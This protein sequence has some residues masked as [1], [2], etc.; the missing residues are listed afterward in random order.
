M[1]DP[2]IS[3]PPN[4]DLDNIT[5]NEDEREELLKQKLLRMENEMNMLRKSLNDSKEQKSQRELTSSNPTTT[6]Y[7]VNNLERSAQQAK[8]EL[9]HKQ[10]L[11]KRRV[12]TFR[13]LNNEYAPQIVDLKE[14][15][16]QKWINKLYLPETVLDELLQGKKILRLPKL[17][18]KVRPPKFKEPDYS[19]WV[20][21]G[22]V[23]SKS[24][25]KITNTVN[26][27][28]KYIIF[29]L[30]DFTFDIKL[31]IFGNNN[32]SKYFNLEIGGLIA[33]L[34]PKILPWRTE[35]TNNNSASDVYK[36]FNLSIRHDCNNILEIGKSRDFG[37][38]PIRNNNQS[39]NSPINKSV[40]DR[41]FYHK[42]LQL[43]RNGSQRL[44][45]NSTISRRG[46]NNKELYLN[47]SNTSF[48]I[49]YSNNH[50]NNNNN[51][52]KR[53]IGPITVTAAKSTFTSLNAAKA[54][55]D[56][57][58]VNPEMFN[59]LENKRRKI[60][61]LNTELNLK[62]QLGIIPSSKTKKEKTELFKLSEK[63]APMFQNYDPTGG[64]L[65]YI[66]Q[67][68]D[69]GVTGNDK[70]NKKKEAIESLLSIKKDKVKLKRS[71]KEINQK[72]KTKDEIWLRYHGK[73]ESDDDDDHNLL[74]IKK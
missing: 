54:F 64:K 36:S 46:P 68:T 6:S 5:D 39:C 29:G 47:K 40:E 57:D 4:D 22:I 31:Y 35:D 50:N 30:T 65:K 55:F 67:H 10:E 44:E 28:V 69:N 20:T 34:N 25:I 51:N 49:R 74:I 13:N 53:K 45:L 52:N 73:D 59:N 56:E 16:S 12:H 14:K 19:N 23:S 9:A 3:N 21:F 48:N 26:N 15:Y 2:R 8:I 60:K 43:R 70:E 1:I 58:F 71:K 11:L 41:C 37:L 18:A 33:I 72:R 17:F 61:D 42:E 27:P 66:L 62:K 38:C 32:V 24:E 7:F 63:V